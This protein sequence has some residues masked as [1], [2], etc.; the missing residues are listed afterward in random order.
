MLARRV[1]KGEPEP[2][3]GHLPRGCISLGGGGSRAFS[4]DFM[5]YERKIVQ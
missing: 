3:E 5:N 2:R 4:L 1:G